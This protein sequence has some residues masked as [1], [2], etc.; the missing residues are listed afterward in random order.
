MKY[1]MTTNVQQFVTSTQQLLCHSQ[2]RPH[3]CW[4][5]TINDALQFLTDFQEMPFKFQAVTLQPKWDIFTNHNII[6]FIFS[7]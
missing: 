4:H 6:F 7:D 3:G 2:H 1:E 5:S